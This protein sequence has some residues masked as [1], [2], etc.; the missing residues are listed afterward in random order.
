MKKKTLRILGFADTTL[1]EAFVDSPSGDVE[2]WGINHMYQAQIV[3]KNMGRFTRWF[4]IHSRADNKNLDGSDPAGRAHI[5]ALSALDMPVY[6][7]KIHGDI[8]NEVYFPAHEILNF[9]ENTLNIKPYFAST[10]TWMVGFAIY[11]AWQE[12]GGDWK[13]FKWKSIELYGVDMAMGWNHGIQNEYSY[14]RPSCEWIIGVLQGLRMSGVEVDFYLPKKSSLFKYYNNYG[15]ETQENNEYVNHLTTRQKSIRSQIEELRTAGQRL[16][17]DY[18]RQKQIIDTN[19]NRMQA[20]LAE[21]DYQLSSFVHAQD[22]FELYKLQNIELLQEQ[23][24]KLAKENES[25][26]SMNFQEVN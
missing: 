23:N 17:A 26:K 13:N 16:D 25:L 21:L 20:V 12:C 22:G 9:F 19:L 18:S 7:Q 4:D 14:Q 11:E 10:A 3:Q 15:Y 1:G 6:V 2:I 5:E 8:E 24:A